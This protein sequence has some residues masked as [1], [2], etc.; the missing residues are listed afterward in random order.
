[1]N[2]NPIP[3]MSSSQTSTVFS[4]DTELRG[5]LSFTT[6]LEFNGRFEGDL[7][8]NGPLII[9]EKAVIKADI[10]ATSSVVIY[11]KVKGNISAKEKIELGP[12]AHLYGDV[13]CPKFMISEGAIFI[14][15]A[16]TLDGTAKPSDEFSNLFKRLT[17]SGKMPMDNDKKG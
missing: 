1:M 6:K 8:A 2:P 12:K 7:Q 3:S 11:G 10:Q 17:G 4:E 14:G 13:R 9:G 16:D 5:S 15:R